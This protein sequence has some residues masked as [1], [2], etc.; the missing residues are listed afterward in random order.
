MRSPDTF[1]DGQAPESR[2]AERVAG[3]MQRRTGGLRR[4]AGGGRVH[5]PHRRTRV[6]RH[7]ELGLHHAR[8]GQRAR[9]REDRHR[10]DLRRAVGGVGGHREA[11]RRGCRAGRGDARR[12]LGGDAARRAQPRAD[13]VWSPRRSRRS[14]SRCGTCTPGWS[15]CRSPPLLGAVHEATPIYGSGGFTSYDDRMLADQLARLGR[16]GHPAGEDEDRAGP[17]GGP[18]PVAVARNAVGDDV[19]LF[20]DANGAYSR[21]QALGWAQTARRVRRPLARGAGQLRRPR[22]AAPGARPRARRDGHRRR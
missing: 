10:V 13:R 17:R 8:R 21:K 3:V 20:V 16:G 4:A 15:T 22:R 5:D 19:E 2:A 11:G 1:A 14:T 6:R 18:R 7:A 12:V 9:G